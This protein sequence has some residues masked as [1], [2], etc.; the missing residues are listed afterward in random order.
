MPIDLDVPVTVT[1]AAM[2]DRFLVCGFQVREADYNSGVALANPTVTIYWAKLDRATSIVKDRGAYSFPTTGFAVE[3]PDRALSFRAN[4]K[5]RLYKS[6]QDA[7]VFPAG[8]V[9]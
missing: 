2:A 4:I 1:P 8:T 3:Q 9:S 5:A 7:G 6:L